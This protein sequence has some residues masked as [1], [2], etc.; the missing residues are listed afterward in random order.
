MVSSVS[1]A[2]IVDLIDKIVYFCQ[3]KGISHVEV[4]DILFKKFTLTGKVSIEELAEILM[5]KFEFGETDAILLARYMIEQ[6]ITPNATGTFK[7][8]SKR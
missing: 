6:D 4:E 8:D 2:E 5:D 3:C 7:Y 1:K